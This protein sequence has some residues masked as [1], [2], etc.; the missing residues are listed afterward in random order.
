M[1][2]VHTVTRIR[3]GL[4]PFVRVIMFGNGVEAHKW[5][6]IFDLDIQ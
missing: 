2:R 5:T 1:D 3:V 6:D 4:A